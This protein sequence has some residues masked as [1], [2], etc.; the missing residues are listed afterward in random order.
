M[1]NTVWRAFDLA[2]N[3]GCHSVYEIEA[4]LKREGYM[5]AHEHLF[6]KTIRQQLGK[7]IR[8]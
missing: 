4:Q 3:G 2:K 5:G 1:A 6:G 8:V 7:L